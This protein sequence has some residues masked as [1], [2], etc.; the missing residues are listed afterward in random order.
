ML[1]N[2]ERIKALDGLRGICCI[3][4]V[5]L[6]YYGTALNLHGSEIPISEMPFSS[7]LGYF[8]EYGGM[9]VD[10][11]FWLSGFL[12]ARSYKDRLREM[13]LSDYLKSRFRS[14]YPMVFASITVGIVIS[15][16]DDIFFASRCVAKPIDLWRIILSYSLLHTGWIYETDVMPFGS[17]VWFVCALLKCYVIYWIVSNKISKK[18]YLL[19]LFVL[20]FAGWASHAGRINTVIVDTS[21]LD[22]FGG[23]LLHE[24]MYGSLSNLLK[25]NI[26]K[27]Q[28]TIISLI[29]AALIGISF[30]MGGISPDIIIMVI[31][32]LMIYYCSEIEWTSR[33]LESAPFQRLGKMSMSIYLSH[34]HALCISSIM[35][36]LFKMNTR[37][38]D[39]SAFVA[40]MLT[41]FAVSIMWYRLIQVRFVPFFNKMIKKLFVNW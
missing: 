22:F 23:T 25:T 37:L 34:N 27:G 20:F 9:F 40:I 28:K 1:N 4:I 8:Y 13:K 19:S 3:P 5:L 24:F 11:F 31:I 29:I 36:V 32:P 35:I 7:I 14:L 18:N 2:N 30:V 10:V 12:I 38:T 6:H 21:L 17:G 15:S 41:V 26:S 16:V 39:I 33:I